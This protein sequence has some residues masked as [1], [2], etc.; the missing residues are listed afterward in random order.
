MDSEFKEINKWFVIFVSTVN[1]AILLGAS[2]F[3]EEPIMLAVAP[4][5]V[6]L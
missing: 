2:L 4:I 1:H 5:F 3:F 6:V